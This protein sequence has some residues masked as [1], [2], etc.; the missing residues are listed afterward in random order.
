MEEGIEGIIPRRPGRGHSD[1]LELRVAGLGQ[2]V[3]AVGVYMKSRSRG[4]GSV[5]VS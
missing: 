4:S 3:A 1:A 2:V 5:V